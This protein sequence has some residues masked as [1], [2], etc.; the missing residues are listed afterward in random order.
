MVTARDGRNAQR[1]VDAVTASAGEWVV[2]S[3]D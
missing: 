1:L 2:V 3:Y